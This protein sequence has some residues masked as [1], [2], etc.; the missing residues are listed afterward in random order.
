MLLLFV[1]NTFSIKTIQQILLEFES[2]IREASNENIRWYK[3]IL[4]A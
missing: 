1:N 4:W 3:Y 2:R